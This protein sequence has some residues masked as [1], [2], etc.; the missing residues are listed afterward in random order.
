MIVVN[1]RTLKKLRDIKGWSQQKLADKSGLDKS[2][3]YRIENSETGTK[4]VQE[5]KCEALAK[6]LDVEV[7]ALASESVADIPRQELWPTQQTNMRLKVSVR[8]ALHLVS[9][10]YGVSPHAVI[11]LA[12][13]MFHLL[14]AGSLKRRAER[15][16]KL[17]RLHGE[18]QSEASTLV[19]YPSDTYL[20]YV[21][22]F[23]IERQSIKDE[24]VVGRTIEQLLGEEPSM[25]DRVSYDPDVN[26]PFEIFLQQV[27]EEWGGD[28]E[29]EGLS[30]YRVCTEYLVEFFGGNHEAANAVQNGWVRLSEIPKDLILKNDKEKRAAWVLDKRADWAHENELL[31]MIDL[32]ENKSDE[33]IA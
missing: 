16:A 2:T 1:G 32:G 14:A 11:E 28:V 30:D 27:A 33:E 3:I 4:P 13:L 29:L 21:V 5:A 20:R 15:L 22:A 17:E 31:S 10:R 8:N 23:D 7:D 6:A 19:E 26:S 12:P 9:I 24:D 18:F 25:D